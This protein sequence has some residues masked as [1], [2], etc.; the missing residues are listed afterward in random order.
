MTGQQVRVLQQ[1]LQ[2]IATMDDQYLIPAIDGVYGSKTTDA[3]RQFQRLNGLTPTGEADSTTQKAIL[4]QYE[5][6]LALIADPQPLYPFPSPYHLVRSGDTGTFI[7]IVQA[8]L[9]ELAGMYGQ[10]TV[11]MNGIYDEATEAAVRR[12]QVV[13]GSPENGILDRFVWD[14]LAKLY[15]MRLL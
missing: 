3:V 2:M 11:A 1:Q 12:W 14:K 5:D 9:N 13:M 10:P 15:N 8:V 4:A 6:V 7:G